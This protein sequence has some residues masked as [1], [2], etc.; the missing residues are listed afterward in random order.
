MRKALNKVPIINVTFRIANAYVYKGNPMH[1]KQVAPFELWKQRIGKGLLCSVILGCI[2][3][4]ALNYFHIS[5][6]KP[7]SIILGIFPSILGFGIGVF[8]LLFALPTEFL[9]KLRESVKNSNGESKIVGPEML[10]ADMAY[11]L[12]VYS[13]IMLISVIL[14]AL[15]D[16]I[17]STAMATIMLLYGL[18][19]T[20]E[21]L[22]SIFMTASYMLISR[23]NNDPQ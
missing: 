18:I 2:M 21:L 8:A 3:A 5:D 7:E 14:G 1:F 6:F 12:L 22:N 17:L 15:P 20:L 16:G 19:V 9:D 10:P 13:I 23:K 11:P 4:F